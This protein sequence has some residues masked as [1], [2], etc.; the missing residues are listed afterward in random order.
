MARISVSVA[1]AVISFFFAFSPS[2]ARIQIS[3][4]KYDAIVSQLTNPLP[5]SEVKASLRLPSQ[6]NK[7]KIHAAEH[8]LELDG[9]VAR[10]DPKSRPIL[11]LPRPD[12]NGQ[13][14]QPVIH[15]AES[16][17]KKNKM[18][19]VHLPYLA[20]PVKNQAD[21]I[22]VKNQTELPKNN[23]ESKPVLIK[24][25]QP[26]SSEKPIVNQVELNS[27]AAQPKPNEEETRHVKPETNAAAATAEAI[28]LEQVGFRPFNRQFRLRSRLPYRLCRHSHL[29]HI[30]EN[31][32][33]RSSQVEIPYGNGM[34][35]TFAENGDFDQEVFHGS[36]NHVPPKL[37]P[38][39]HHHRPHYLRQQG[40]NVEEVS[41]H[42]SKI[43]HEK[44][45]N[46]LA[47]KDSQNV[48]STRL[49]ENDH[50]GVRRVPSKPTSFLHRNGPHHLHQHEVIEKVSNRLPENNHE[51]DSNRLTENNHG[52]VSKIPRKWMPFLHNL[53]PLHLH[54]HDVNE[55]KKAS[56]SSPEK[57][58]KNSH[59]H[60][61]GGNDEKKPEKKRHRNEKKENTLRKRIRKFLGHYFDWT[62]PTATR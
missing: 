51:K 26:E 15:Q 42:L 55:D 9:K 52:S 34:M 61:H 47:E 39:L 21:S 33:S 59:N 57:K 35:I 1:V 54:Q 46:R 22:A 56:Q 14:A 49:P 58:P 53:G 48:I 38:F 18:P 60:H 29:H 28:P 2:V 11:K 32:P 19:V 6:S 31:I 8:R 3:K 12:L 4:P 50:S 5:G 30:E 23:E 25:P 27:E 44:V 40:V 45:S 24:K 10:P 13:I 36:F 62:T 7:V 41:K 43:A 17:E 37:F 16:K 20:L